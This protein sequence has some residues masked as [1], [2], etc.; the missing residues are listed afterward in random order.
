M[1]QRFWRLSELTWEFLGGDLVC[2][3]EIL[4]LLERLLKW[5]R[6]ALYRIFWTS[7]YCGVLQLPLI[8]SMA[9]ISIIFK[10]SRS[11]WF[12][13]ETDSGSKLGIMNR[14]TALGRQCGSGNCSSVSLAFMF[15]KIFYTKADCGFRRFSSKEL[16]LSWSQIWSLELQTPESLE[17]PSPFFISVYKNHVVVFFNSGTSGGKTAMECY[18]WRLKSFWMKKTNK[19]GESDSQDGKC[20]NIL[21]NKSF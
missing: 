10:S 8:V 7:F 18:G 2:A 21:G 15:P 14:V 6:D 17:I 1:L 5:Y 3:L 9:F 13:E 11:C 19:I 20:L 16:V 12:P 4:E